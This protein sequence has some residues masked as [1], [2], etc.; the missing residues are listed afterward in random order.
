MALL[1]GALLVWRM[2]DVLLLVFAAILVA[3][4]LHAAADGLCWL[5]PIGRG[6]ALALGGLLI[7]LVLGGVGALFGHELTKQ[8]SDLS[9]LLPAAWERFV[10]WVGEDRV[11]G[12]L[13][14]IS[15]N[16]ATVASIAQTSIGLVTTALSGLVLAVLGGIY[17]AI[18]PRMYHRGALKLLPDR[19]RAPVADATRETAQGLRNWLLGQLISMAAT[20]IAVFIGLSLIGVPS[21]LALAIIAGL[22]EFIPLVGPFLGAVPAVLIALTAGVGP[23]LWTIGFFVVWQ[24]IEGNAMAPLVM[25]F[26]VSIPPAVTLFAL[27]LFGGL[28]G[29]IGVLLGGPLTVAAWILVSKLWV[30]QAP[31]QD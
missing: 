15:P 28:F 31:Q 22:F 2:H 8:L 14:G 25:R 3:V 30:G 5:L 19:A 21:A 26:A 9:T 1:A 27:F 11:Q 17:L 18:S 24:Q 10:E 7:V 20:G 29:V 4:I 12:A 6:V 16:G 23:F 13:D